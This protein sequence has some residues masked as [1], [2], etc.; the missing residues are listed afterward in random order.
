MVLGDTISVAGT[1]PYHTVPPPSTTTS[2]DGYTLTASGQPMA[3]MESE[4]TLTISPGR[5][6]RH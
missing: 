3:G 4:L 2:V 6:A 5:Q 1:G